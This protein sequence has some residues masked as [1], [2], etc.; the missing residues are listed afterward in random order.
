MQY[1]T[2]KTPALDAIFYVENPCYIDAT[3]YFETPAIDAMLQ[4]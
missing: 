1:F 4:M 2:L 3:F